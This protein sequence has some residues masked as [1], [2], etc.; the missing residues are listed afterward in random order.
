MKNSNESYYND[1]RTYNYEQEKSITTEEE[2]HLAE[3]IKASLML[4]TQFT[5]SES[6]SSSDV[7]YDND[8]HVVYNKYDGDDRRRSESNSD[9]KRPS[10]TKTKTTTKGSK[11][12]VVESETEF[13]EAKEEEEEKKGPS[14]LLLLCFFL[15]FLEFCGALLAIIYWDNIVECCGESYMSND[16]WNLALFGIAVAYLTWTIVSGPIIAKTHEPFFLFNPMIGFLLAMHMLYTTHVLNAYIIYGIETFA[17]LGQTYVLCQIGK[18]WELLIHTLANF[19]V[20]LLTIYMIISLSND[21]GYC[22]VDGELQSIF[23]NSTCSNAR[24]TDE[25]SCHICTDEINECFISFS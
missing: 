7:Y 9:I 16:T 20:S 10:S 18:R 8:D 25:L 12:V 19:T 13:D 3:A 21:G 4:D 22:I 15:L 11:E 5:A 24:C 14:C 6:F 1:N 23:S 17:M 2:S